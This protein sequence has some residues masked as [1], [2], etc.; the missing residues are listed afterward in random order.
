M[1][2]FYPVE[3]NLEPCIAF[4]F[5]VSFMSFNLQ[6]SSAFFFMIM[7]FLKKNIEILKEND[8]LNY[9]IIE[10]WLRSVKKMNEWENK[11]QRWL[12]GDRNNLRW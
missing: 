8:M 6:S 7:A 2:K 9:L 3:S 1:K 4:H 12:K 11:G 10:K 5:L